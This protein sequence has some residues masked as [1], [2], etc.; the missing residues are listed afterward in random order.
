MVWQ[1]QWIWRKGETTPRNA[2]LYARKTFELQDAVRKALAHCVADSRYKLFV[3]KRF[4]GRGPVR[5]DPRWQRYDTYDL[6]KLLE[7][8]INVVAMLVHHLGSGS[9]SYVLGRAGLLFQCDVVHTNGEL[10]QVRSDRTWRVK[11]C[12]AWADDAPRIHP[13]AGF[14]EV[15][16]ARLGVDG[17]ESPDLDDTDWEE[18]QVIG[19]PPKRPWLRLCPRDVPALKEEKP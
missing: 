9:S 3:N 4:V 11:R 17:W 2:Y 6:S 1:A 13:Q 18:P 19:K 5:S 14:A 7:P 10:T 15:Y 16:D 12:T 8:G